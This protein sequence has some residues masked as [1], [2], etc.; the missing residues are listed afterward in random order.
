MTS[1]GG[2]EVGRV[3]VKVVPDTSEFRKKLEAELKKIQ[4]GLEVEIPVTLDTKALRAQLAKLKAELRGLKGV[5]IPLSFGGGGA[6]GGGAGVSKTIDNLVVKSKTL[7]GHFQDIATGAKDFADT[8]R[9]KGMFAMDSIQKSAASTG[10]LFKNLWSN[11]PIESYSNGLKRVGRGLKNVGNGILDSE[12][13]FKKF[14]NTLKSGLSSLSEFGKGAFSSIQEGLSGIGR[15]GGIV[16]AVLIL[17]P[18]LL[19]L[20]A[21]LI[22][23][24][25]SILAALG[26]GA[27]VVALGMDGI[28]KS[29]KGL[30]DQLGP[31]QKEISATFEKGLTPVFKTLGGVIKTF[32]PELNN[33]AKALVG[34]AKGFTDAL[35]SAQGMDDLKTLLQ[36]TVGLFQN[37][38]PIVQSF[39]QGF[40]RIAA[41][42]SKQFGELAGVFQ[43]FVDGFNDVMNTAIANGTFAKAISGLAQVFDALFTV[44]NQFI[45]VGLTAMAD[46]G[47]PLSDAFRAFGNLLVGIMPALTALSKAFLQIFTAL[48]ETLGP[49]FAR[50][51]PLFQEFFS[52]IGTVLADVVTALGPVVEEIAKVALELF[53]AFKPVFAQIAPVVKILGGIFVTVLK[54]LEPLL[55]VIAG[56]LQQLGEAIGGALATAAPI[57]QQVATVLGAAL[58]EAIKSIAPLIG[59]LV[60]SLVSLFLAFVPLIQP[61]ADIAIDLIPELARTFVAIVPPVISFITTVVE[62]ATTLI[63]ILMP[64]IKLVITIVGKV[65]GFFADLVTAVSDAFG[66]VIDFVSSIPD[67]IGAFFKAAG[68]WL[69]GAGK[70]ILQGLLDGLLA[71][72]H[73]VTD[74][75]SGI[76]KWIV[77]HKG[78]VSKDKK[79]LIPAGKAIMDGLNAGLTTG[80]STVQDNVAGMAE[81]LAAPFTSAGMDVNGNIT[82]TAT[83]NVVL[84]SDSIAAALA[85]GLAGW[86]WKMNDQAVTKAVNK[87]NTLKKRRG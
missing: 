38:A 12:G 74:F 23:G 40:L 72:W 13:K 16:I 53:N 75:V 62:M 17:L 31:L 48:G 87:G 4:K 41:E 56:A 55:P 80:F 57:L 9:L 76:G 6:G 65:I 46:L 30:T 15:T 52:I 8:L 47:G 33:I 1:P 85:D 21:G 84:Q 7:R 68:T 81:Q 42:G 24:L 11:D 66:W 73:K 61:I 2:S 71:A 78:P 19:G 22:A 26:A 18:P 51:A 67:K 45:G 83:A 29:F 59:P 39:T 32:G 79:M 28:K 49:I 35:S 10:K 14:G 60:S 63:G 54:A 44:F 69:L 77:D 64:A 43:R 86:E 36:N 58:G 34:V 20:I 5:N 82:S 25:P 27:L 50:L 37:L 3:S 70:A